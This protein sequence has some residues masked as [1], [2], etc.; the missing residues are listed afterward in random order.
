MKEFLYSFLSVGLGCGVCSNY[1]SVRQV[2]GRSMEP[3]LYDRE[4]VLIKKFNFHPIRKNELVVFSHPEEKKLAVKLAGGFE[5]D[6]FAKRVSNEQ[7]RVGKGHFWA[8]SA[9]SRLF[10][11]SFYYGPVPLG[12]IIGKPI[13]V[14]SFSNFQ[15]RPVKL[16]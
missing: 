6:L 7:V 11:D 15:I 16:S 3:F 2:D 5:G 1:I 4:W 13:A 12:L 14:L 9:N 10:K 8:Q